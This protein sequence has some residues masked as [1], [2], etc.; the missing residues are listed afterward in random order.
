MASFYDVFGAFAN[1]FS[2]LFLSDANQRA[3]Y[4]VTLVCSRFL[5]LWAED[6]AVCQ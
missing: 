4:S 6:E 2:V 1:L 5:F 3:A